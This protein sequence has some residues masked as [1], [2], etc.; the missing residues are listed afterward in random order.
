MIK[1]KY[2]AALKTI[3]GTRDEQQDCAFQQID[4]NRVV[5]AVCDGMGGLESG[6]LASA[7]TIE[8]FKELLERKAP[9]ESF[10]SFYLNSVDIL[11]ELVFHLKNEHGEKLAAGTTFLSVAI[12][13]N[14]LSWLSV[15][16]SR[17]YILRGNEFVQV[18]RDHNYFLQLDQMKLE[19][20]ENQYKA[21]TARGEVL[22]SFIGMGGIEVMDISHS[23]FKLL[24]N[25]TVLLSTDGL[26]KALNDE[27]IMQ[28]LRTE[29]VEEA[30]TLLINRVYEKAH[31]FQDNTT[32]VVIKYN[33]EA[34]YEAH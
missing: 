29:D 4:G 16:D 34:E 30:V 17:L 31:Q 26:Y 2:A 12:E 23:P 19:I 10:S 28:C 5:A 9:A 6:R 27:E 22:I 25:D 8:K 33:G 24:P 20:S 21:E 32:C 14:E 1:T 11:D 15:G 13:N 7:L 18:T 3:I